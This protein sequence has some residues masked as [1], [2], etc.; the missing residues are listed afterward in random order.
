[1]TKLVTGRHEVVATSRSR[2][3]VTGGAASNTY[4]SSRK[5]CGPPQPGALVLPAPEIEDVAAERG[6]RLRDG[7]VALQ[8][9]DECIGD[10]RGRGLL[11]GLGLVKDRRSRCPIRSLPREWHGNA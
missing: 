4:S 11:L 10:V 9:P 8:Q 3:G 1:M 7:L 2:H 6:R 5:G